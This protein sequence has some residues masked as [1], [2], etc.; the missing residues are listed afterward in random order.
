MAARSTLESIFNHVALPPKLPGKADTQCESVEKDLIRRMLETV[1]VMKEGCELDLLPNWQMIENTLKLSALANEGAICNES[2]LVRVFKKISLGGSVFLRIKEQNAGILV[3]RSPGNNDPN[4]IFE[5]FEI[6]ASAEQALAKG[7][8]QWDF[9]GSAVLVPIDV[10]DKPGFRQNLA[11]F[12]EKASSEYLD[13]FAVKVRKAGTEV[14]EERNTVHPAIITQLLMTLLE[15]NGRRTSL[16]VLRKRVKDNVCWD[17]AKLPWRRSPFWLT[18]KVCIQRLLYLDLGGQA[19]RIQYKAMMCLFLARLLSDC[20]RELT[21]SQY[22]FL[23]VKLCRRLAKLNAEQVR[24]GTIDDTPQ[25]FVIVPKV[26]EFFCAKSIDVATTMLESE[27]KNWKKDFLRRVPKL[28]SRAAREDHRLSLPNSY[29]Y[30]R[31]TLKG[32]QNHRF[33]AK[34]IEP[35]LLSGIAAKNTSKDFSILINTY[36]SL[37]IREGAI[38]SD[39]IDIPA[40][41]EATEQKCI[42]LA[43]S[44]TDYINAVGE[45]YDGNSEQMSLFILSI[46]DLWVAM[47]KCATAAYPLLREYHPWF[48]PE[49]LDVLLLP[50][51]KQ[52][53]RLQ[54]IQLHLQLRCTG[55]KHDMMTIFAGPEQGCFAES[56]VNL[57]GSSL[58]R[59]CDSIV[60]SSSIFRDHKESE[61]VKVNREFDDL[62]EKLKMSSCTQLRMPDGSHDIRGCKHCFYMRSRRRLEIKVHED[63]LPMEPHNEILQRSMVF[64]LKPPRAFAAYREATWNIVNKLCPDLGTTPKAKPEVLL[65][66]HPPLKNFSDRQGDTFFSLASPTKSF[67]RTHYGYRGLPARPKDVLLPHGMQWSYYDS[68]RK[69][70]AIEYPQRLSFAHHFVLDIPKELPF[71]SLYSSFTFAPDG[72]GPTSYEVISNIGECPSDLTVHEYSAH[73]SLIGGRNR[74][75]LS[76]LAELGSSNINFTLHD[77]TTLFHHIVLQ[78]GPRLPNDAM[79]SIHVTFRDLTFCNRLAE[80][81]S[82]H[83]EVIA[84]NWRETNYMETL[85]TLS[86]RLFSLGHQDSRPE[87]RRLLLRI[88]EVTANWISLLRNETRNAQ[89]VNYSGRAARYCFLSALLCRRTFS[90]FLSS[91]SGLDSESLRCFFEASLAMQE[92]LVVDVTEFTRF[93]RS[94]LVRDI[95]MAALLLPV[96]RAGV[97]K[98]PGSLGNAIDFVWPDGVSTQRQ[99]GE[100][101]LLPSPYDNWATSTTYAS[102]G[103]SSQIF[104]FHLLEGHL[105]IN[106]QTVGKLPADIRDSDILRELFGD[107]RLFAQPSSLRGMDYVLSNRAGDHHIHLGYRDG[108]LIIQARLFDST[109]ELVPRGVFGA[110]PDF[111]IPLFLIANCF[112]WLDLKTGVLEIRQ[113]PRI[114]IK[115]RNNWTIDVRSRTAHRKFS[116]LIDPFSELAQTI[117]RIFLHFEDPFRLTIFQP[118]HGKLSIELKRME[119][120]FYVTNAGQLFCRQ[121]S[122]VVDRHQDAGTLYGLQSM[123]LLRDAGDYSQRSIITPIGPVSYKRYRSHVY[124]N[125]EGTGRYARYNINEELGRLESPAEPGLLYSKALLHAFTSHLLPDPLTGRTGTQE[126]LACLDSGYCQPW[127]PLNSD[128]L[129]VLTQLSNL[130]PRREYY[131]AN[132]RCQQ[133]VHW[134]AELPTRIQSD[135]FQTAVEKLIAK[136]NRLSQFSTSSTQ[137]TLK[138][139]ANDALLHERARWRQSIYAS[140]EDSRREL[141]RPGD[142]P[143]V[144]RDHWCTSKATSNVCE[145]V[146]LLRHKP[147]AIHTTRKLLDLLES[148]PYIGGYA[149]SFGL[150]DIGECLNADLAEQWG[151]LVNLCRNAKDEDVYHL[152]FQV[153]TMAFSDNVDMTVLKVIASFFILRELK[154]LVPPRQASFIGFRV[155]ERPT[156]DTLLPII[157]ISYQP[158]KLTKPSRRAKVQDE[159]RRLGYSPDCEKKGLELAEMLVR[160]WP[161]EQP[162]IEGFEADNLNLDEAMKA[163]LSE[164]QRMHHNAQLQRHII[165]V[166]TI[167]NS[168]YREAHNV[169]CPSAPRSRLQQE[170]MGPSRPTHFCL[171]RLGEDLLRKPAYSTVTTSQQRAYLAVPDDDRDAVPVTSPEGLTDKDH[172]SHNELPSLNSDKST[173]LEG[174]SLEI[175]ELEAITQRLGQ[176]DCAVRSRYAHDLSRSIMALKEISKPTEV[177][178][179]RLSDNLREKVKLDK[180]VAAARTEL[181]GRYRKIASSLSANDAKYTWL[182]K[183]NLWPRLT[184]VTLLQQL[185]STSPHQ[186]GPGMRELFL[187]YALGIAK[188]QKLLRMR[189]AFTQHDESKLG[190]ERA[191]EGHTNWDASEFPDWLLLEIDANIQ[192]RQEQ[193]T[194]AQEMVSPTSGANSVLQMNMGQGKTSVI[195]PMVAAVL[196]NGQMLNRILVPKAL[197]SQAAQILQSRLGGLLGRDIVH[198]PFSRRTRTTVSLINE[199]YELHKQVLDTS[200]I[201]LGIPEHI[202]SFKLSGLQRLADSKLPEAVGMIEGQKW[203]DEVCRDVLDECDFT[204]AVKTQLIYPGGAQL[205]VDGHPSRWEVAM[206]VLGLV[207]FH[208]KDL[209]RDYPQS[210]DILE[211]NSAGFPV[212]HILRKD[213]E[214]ALTGKIVDDICNRRTSILPLGECNESAREAIKIFISEENIEKRVAKRIERLFPDTPKARKSVYLLRGLLV[215]GILI[216]CLKKRWNV[217]YGLHHGRDPIAVPFHAKGV[218]SDQAEWGHPDVAIL[219][220]CLAFYYEGLSVTQF[221]KSLEAVLKS[222]HPATEYDRWTQRSTTLP[223][224]LRHWNAITVDDAGLVGEIWR[225]LRFTPVVINYFLSN[226]VFPLHAKQFATKLQASGW[227]VP[228]YSNSTAQV[229]EGIRPSITTGFSGTNDNRRLLPLTIEQHDLPSLSHTNAE[230]LTYLLQPRNRGYRVTADNKGKRLSEIELL[231]TLHLGN[232][233]IL[234]DAGAFIMEMDN[235]TVAWAWLQEEW[236]VHGAVY[237]HEDNKPWV[238]YRNG[239]RVPLFASPFA[240]DMRDC[241]V[242]LDEAHTRGTDLKLPADAVGAL[243]L[244]LNQTKD[245]TVQAAMRL[246]QLGTTQSVRFLAPPEVHQSI[247]DVCNKTL[248]ETVDSSDVITW[249]LDQTCAT[250]RELQPLYFAQGK[251]FCQRTQAATSYKK[252]LQNLEHRKSYLNALQQPEQHSLEQLYEPNYPSIVP[253]SSTDKTSGP[254]DRVAALVQTLEQRRQ[255]SQAN[256]SALG[257][258]LEEVEQERE[259]AYEIEEEREI[260]R[261]RKPK[262]LKFPGLHDSILSFAKGGTLVLDNIVPASEMLESTQL[263]LKYAINGATLKDDNY[264]RPVTWF[265]FNTA[266]EIALVIIPEEAEALIPALRDYHSPDTHLIMYS[267]PCTR[268]MVHFS[269][270]DYYALPS[271]PSGWKP[272]TWLPFELGILGGRLYFEFSEYEDILARLYSISGDPTEDDESSERWVVAKSRLIFLQEWLA[273]RRQGQ[274]ISDTPMGHVCQD[275][276]LR[277]DHPFF[278]TRPVGTLVEN[279]PGL[280]SLRFDVED[281]EEDYFSNDDDM[282]VDM[283]D[284]DSSGASEYEDA[285]V[286]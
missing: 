284:L 69:Q 99:Y 76:I 179:D 39:Q 71:S 84:T 119:L 208:L 193:V 236:A 260:E 89:D 176:S 258:A 47:D 109:L 162:S 79:R 151:A 219:F 42:D 264:T 163:L 252:F 113:K 97:E 57:P 62:T 102:E 3:R 54:A 53:K 212:A 94:L 182:R 137:I 31:D 184:P 194:V 41:R 265:L 165:K 98:H 178:C 88:R 283:M 268:S 263:G 206:T 16:P 34:T 85:L 2:A 9:P 257:S 25:T 181:D 271:L 58:K 242:Y 132:K 186:F 204:L 157:R 93:T 90:P 110:G 221:K 166:Q 232:I 15:A 78:A 262:A 240:D 55:S 11:S 20:L 158:S 229:A 141:T 168:Y 192:I 249:L 170:I 177:A 67:L 104:F 21:S 171:P 45:S 259:V 101:K 77:T 211:R 245:N 86:I 234:I 227:D 108:R 205:A 222:D 63:L 200:G 14:S 172:H 136:S 56:Y 156:T 120:D 214:E 261:P 130:T 213:A 138:I 117:S 40:T 198:V 44:I 36:S 272:P 241:V 135:E 161:C 223:E 114:W 5:A 247:L 33:Q 149:T 174:R 129:D 107:Q 50:R 254:W 12:L 92:S 279:A 95:K 122:A 191:D 278:T 82:R 103:T 59:L 253:S 273:I 133:I 131:P 49:N 112:H 244:G 111:D 276:Q 159:N 270:L 280:E 125:V 118:P 148:W 266:T 13:Q 187:G 154:N 226:F 134:D 150:Y 127:T 81:V 277:S 139:E 269:S 22:E 190:Q 233:R 75:W 286:E 17:N 74:R 51:W 105:V 203:L 30:L 285:L 116:T 140:P 224:T 195:M 6:S 230:V 225:H 153:G 128:F 216:L 250:N 143:Y 220:T 237:F 123:L 52:L 180:E 28:P 231:K 256:V 215:H 282:D 142:L 100:W 167:L 121:L 235:Y 26:V 65:L 72:L 126:A 160:Q 202:L 68:K 197:L 207:S 18:L 146:T 24:L 19:G 1:I 61:L 175:I 91:R 35:K 196:A 267:A 164:W 217:Q 7:T 124:V 8:L 115:R 209:A 145:M 238:V 10:F 4:V 189:Q 144:S 83:V 239:K 23:K 275:L 87:S 152:M 281:M 106:G 199:Y 64:E 46:F 246:R 66:G 155:D 169:S 185:R 38:E 73:Q 27:W 80:Q 188:L 37:A 218:P 210:I 255:E 96:L 60:H 201:I 228:L 173:D 183:G 147:S 251:D 274:D 29:A 70:W 32:L 243:T 43:L 248:N 48:M